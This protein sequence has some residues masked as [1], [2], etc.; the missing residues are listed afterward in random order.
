MNNLVMLLIKRGIVRVKT[1]STTAS[2]SN[3]MEEEM[4]RKLLAKHSLL[5]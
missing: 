1:G 3:Y 4:K 5:I 2:G